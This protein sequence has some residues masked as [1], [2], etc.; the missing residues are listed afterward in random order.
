MIIP[1]PIVN[2]IWE[3]NRV[4]LFEKYVHD[5][6]YLNFIWEVANLYRTPEAPLQSADDDSL[7]KKENQK[8]L[9]KGKF[10][11]NL[12][13]IKYSTRFMMDIGSRAKTDSPMFDIW[14]S[15]L[16]RLY[17]HNK[18]VRTILSLSLSRA[19]QW[20]ICSI[21]NKRLVGGSCNGIEKT[22]D[23]WWACWWRVPMTMCDA[24]SSSS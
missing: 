16:K 24:P 17:S 5:E 10:D 20:L 19:I 7:L 14:I 2:D 3:E 4:F 1:E 18:P 9:K 23:D 21:I 22:Q 12:T 15:H 8:L 11:P 6:D 13:T